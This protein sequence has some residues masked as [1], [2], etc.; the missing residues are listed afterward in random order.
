MNEATLHRLSGELGGRFKLTAL[1]QKRLIKL[2]VDR[3]DIITKNSGGR[4]VR[5]VIDEIASGKLQLTA[6]GGEE[7]TPELE[8][9]AD[10][11]ADADADAD[12]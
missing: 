7:L 4:P 6:P 9:K 12:E 5:L 2:M 8:V 1:L 10:E 3:D 11:P